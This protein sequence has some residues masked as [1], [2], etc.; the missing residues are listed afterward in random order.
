MIA[1]LEIKNEKKSKSVKKTFFQK[2]A[3][4]RFFKFFYIEIK[5]FLQSAPF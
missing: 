1:K 5:N 3:L 2:G 4:C